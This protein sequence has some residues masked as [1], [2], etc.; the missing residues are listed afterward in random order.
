MIGAIANAL[1]INRKLKSIFDYRKVAL[2]KRFGV[3]QST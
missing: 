2:E 1:F 3:Y